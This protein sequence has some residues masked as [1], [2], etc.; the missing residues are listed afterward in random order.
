VCDVLS[1][2][3]TLLSDVL[4]KSVVQLVADVFGIAI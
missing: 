2:L 3:V 4:N 1:V